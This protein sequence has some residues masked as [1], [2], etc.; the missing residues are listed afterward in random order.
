M[1]DPNA[2][3]YAAID[4][5]SNTVHL[6][7][8]RC[9]PTDMEILDDAAELVRIG[10]SVT[11]S[12]QI[13][14]QKTAL[15]IDALLRYKQRA[16]A[17]GAQRIFVVATEA[18]RRA[19]NNAEFLHTIQQATGLDI[20]LISGE[21]EAFLTFLGATYS[22][23]AQPPADLAVMDLGGGSTELVLAHYLTITWHTSLPIGSGWLHDHYL[24]NDP[25]S[26]AERETA[27]T[28]LHSLF[29][30]DLPRHTSGLLVATGGTAKTLLELA[31]QAFD[32]TPT[33]HQLSREDLQRCEDLLTALNSEQIAARYTIE[34]PRAR[35]ML[36]GTLII[37]ALLDYWQMDCMQVSSSGLREGSMLA[38]VRY[39]KAWLQLH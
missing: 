11:A 39:G 3:V 7:T 26:Q 4:I 15:T 24:Q 25:P 8:A 35:I 27:L 2:P 17:Y 10:E 32:L 34:A 6:T 1:L 5:G 36:A 22:L 16:L 38:F 28:F 20:H 19:S 12:G 31:Q 29:L 9:S 21:V 33:V 14:E 37:R 13:S 18:I 30:K 23:A